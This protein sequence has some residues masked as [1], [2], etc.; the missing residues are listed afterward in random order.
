MVHPG[1][2]IDARGRRQMDD[3]VGQ[4]SDT[5]QTVRLIEVGQHGSGALVT[6]EGALLG[7]A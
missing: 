5:L 4:T 3:D 2:A 1:D 7:V 6:P